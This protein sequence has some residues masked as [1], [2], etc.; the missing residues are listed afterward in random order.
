M[1][2]LLHDVRRI[3]WRGKVSQHGLH[4]DLHEEL[5]NGVGDILADARVSVVGHL[6]QGA[7]SVV[8]NATVMLK[9]YIPK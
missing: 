2:L 3:I 7:G 6:Y 1:P 4:F 5:S 8:H 9:Y